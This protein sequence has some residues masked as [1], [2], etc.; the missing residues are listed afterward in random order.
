MNVGHLTQKAMRSE[1]K[2][3]PSVQFSHSA[4]ILQVN[5]RLPQ[6]GGCILSWKTLADTLYN[7]KRFWCPREVSP[8]LENG[9]FLTD[10]ESMH[11]YQKP[12]VFSFSQIAQKRCLILLGEPGIGKTYAMR[13]EVEGI[14]ARIDSEDGILLEKNLRDYG[15]DYQ[16]SQDIFESAEIREW[17][18]SNNKLNLFLDSTDEGLLQ[19]RALAPLLLREIKKLPTD[20]LW[21]RITCRT[22]EWPESSEGELRLLFGDDAFGIYTLAPLRRVDVE[23]A[24]RGSNISPH[25]F[26]DE[27]QLKTAVPFAAKPVTLNFLLNL[28]LRDGHLPRRQAELY[29]QG[30]LCLCEESNPL[31]REANDFGKLSSEARLAVASRI[32]AITLFCNRAAVSLS[33]ESGGHDET[34]LSLGDLRGGLEPVGKGH[35]AID[36]D[37]LLDAL[38]TALFAGRGADR[39]GFAH[40]TYAEFL[41]AQFVVDHFMS[42]Q[43]IRN[44]IFHPAEQGDKVVPQLAE[45]A[46]WIA[47]L[48]PGVFRE[49]V[50][51]DPEIL[52]RSDVAAASSENH[53]ALVGALLQALEAEEM[54]DS[55][56]ATREFKKLSHPGLAM[57][58][59]PF[60]VDRHKGWLVRRAAAEIA[61]KCQCRDLLDDLVRIALDPDEPETV[62]THA[63]LSVLEAGDQATKL[64]L[65]PL[66]KGEAGPDPNDELR[67]IA[68]RALW[69]GLLSGK[70]LF[71]SLS[72]PQRQNFV[73]LYRMFLSSGLADGLSAGDLPD[74][75]QY[76]ATLGPRHQISYSFEHTIDSIFCKAWKSLDA[77][78]VLDVFARASLLRL[79]QHDEIVSDSGS[80]GPSANKA[81]REDLHGEPARRRRIVQSILAMP[82]IREDDAFALCSTQTRLVLPEDVP[83]L[84]EKLLTERDSVRFSLLVKLISFNFQYDVSETADCVYRACQ[85]VSAISR[86][87]GTLF[88]PVE[89]GSPS[90]ERMKEL[91]RMENDWKKEV[92]TE[93]AAA[94]RFAGRITEFLSEAVKGN[95]EAWWN[96]HWALTI[97]SDGSRSKE[98]D[99]DLTQLPGWAVCD[100]LTQNKVVE[101]AKGLAKNLKIDPE[102]WVD[103]DTFNLGHVATLR[104]MTLLWKVAPDFLKGLSAT[105]W[106]NWAPPIVGFPVFSDEGAHRSGL[107]EMVYLNAPEAALDVLDSLIE[108]EN[109]KG[110]GLFCLST[111]EGCMDSRLDSFLFEKAQDPGLN[112]NSL[113]SLLER[114]LQRKHVPADSYARSL[115]ALPI[116]S[117]GTQREKAR[118]AAEGLMTNAEDSGWPV[119]GPAILSDS[120]F[121]RELI[122]SA[123]YNH[124][125][126]LYLRIQVEDLAD[127]YVWMTRQY[128][129]REGDRLKSGCISPVDSAV[130]FRDGLLSHIVSKASIGAIH[131]LKRIARTLPELSWLKWEILRAR[132]LM[133]QR[134][135][136]PPMVSEL[137]KLAENADKRFIQSGDDLLAVIVESLERFQAELHG[138]TSV[139]HRLWNEKPNFTPK[140]E[141]RLSDEIKVHL[142]EDLKQRGVIANREVEIRRGEETDIHLDAISQRPG[143][144]GIDTVSAVV[145]VKGCWNRDLEKAM[146]TQLV[147]RYL[148]RNESPFG[149]YVI[150]WFLCDAWADEYRKKDSPDY[151]LD[152]ARI[153]FDSQA[154]ALSNPPL[155]VRAFVLDTR[156][157]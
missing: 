111:V 29:Y 63:A 114:L 142:G 157:R 59:R 31:R 113:A 23:E 10:P 27:I 112:P 136:D 40:Q 89:L 17:T 11:S 58:L 108:K 130:D 55:F 154:A 90:A 78:G 104:V 86:E 36:N 99:S 80:T 91:W 137:L 116:A 46:A 51:S 3:V 9:G 121:G 61:G 150:G 42:I 101:A 152:E 107:V 105:D 81:F 147:G 35:V 34:D 74:A 146:E 75:L 138:E 128:P 140:D 14:R 48:V 87:L 144:Q 143:S 106:K 97:D 20:R 68:L 88:E 82:D 103:L 76:V 30:C 155:R 122:E 19:I 84:V 77:P 26:L 1:P 85:D 79:R 117:E 64:K 69:P 16:L 72:H 149:L 44:L 126:S 131:E 134:T 95:F 66:A 37:S 18:T 5:T 118:V 39:I 83:W 62:R 96:L 52:L 100:A 54:F 65:K 123:S 73:G 38:G 127:L 98:F 60:L 110:A 70:E 2:F 139:V 124:H 7:W 25:D 4:V 56:S 153:K 49:I 109:K 50:M 125:M 12:N 22:A 119:V 41:A 145:E 45:S 32:A 93:K 71:E 135:W 53:A 33:Q 15:S 94:Q 102:G 13:S 57:Q 28:F 24:A 151:S 120:K 156:L 67:G 92:L 47:S 21:L 6:L 129:Y 43:Q 148:K 115:L 133:L 141:G 8:D 132:N